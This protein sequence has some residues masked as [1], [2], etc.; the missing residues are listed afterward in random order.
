MWGPGVLA[1]LLGAGLSL[2]SGG[3]VRQRLLRRLGTAAPGRPRRLPGEGPRGLV[4]EVAEVL[5]A[6]LAVKRAGAVR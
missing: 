2:L 3:A 1:G 6:G 4:D 5:G